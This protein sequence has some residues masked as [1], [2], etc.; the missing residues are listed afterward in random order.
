MHS[1]ATKLIYAVVYEALAYYYTP[2]LKGVFVLDMCS[3][4]MVSY[5]SSRHT[6]E[7][8]QISQYRR[9]G[10]NVFHCLIPL[11]VFFVLDMCSLTMVG[12]CW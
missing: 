8:K 5:V 10:S 7:C 12:L 3:L 11:L 9:K 4:T 1:N 2:L 6:V